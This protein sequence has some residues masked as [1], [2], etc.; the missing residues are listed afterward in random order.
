M[1]SESAAG[2]TSREQ[3]VL[4]TDGDISVGRITKRR[5]RPDHRGTA[6][7][8]AGPET[9]APRHDSP[10]W[11]LIPGVDG[12]AL[13]PG[14]RQAARRDAIL[15][16]ALAAGDVLA[17]L[18]ALA[19]AVYLVPWTHTRMGVTD[20]LLAPLLIVLSKGIGL[21]DRDQHRVRKS[22]IDEVPRILNLAVFYALGVWLAEAVL[23]QGAL[24]RPQVYTLAMTAFVSIAGLRATARALVLRRTS[25]ERIL[26]IGSHTD[27]DRAAKV[28]TRHGDGL[29]AVVVGTVA[30]D[31]RAAGHHAREELD[32]VREVI[33][34]TITSESVE[35]AI[36]A[37]DGFDQEEMLDVIRL[38]KALGIKLSVL[39]R[40]LEVVGSASAFDDLHGLSLLGVRPYGLSKSSR[41]LKRAMDRVRRRRGA[42]GAVAALRTDHASD[43]ARL[44]R[45]DLLPPAPHGPQ[46]RAVR[47]D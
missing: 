38:I 5:R 39:P 31:P 2:P 15:R 26:V 35:R 28:L 12:I 8:R 32:R 11:E 45:P 3:T 25:A 24:D 43:Q 29:N 1:S 16:R 46:G 30:V 10:V 21:Y 13:S 23:I 40:L 14:M 4:R 27:C 6:E 42:H 7:L 44:A 18:F 34:A 41:Q 22:T 33:A 9:L 20:V 47:H 17:C 37:P 19:V 36:V